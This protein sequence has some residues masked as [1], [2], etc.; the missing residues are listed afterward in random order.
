[1]SAPGSLSPR[2]R[3]E[4]VLAHQRPDRVPCDFGGCSVTGMH[5]SAVY[6]LR[7]A[8]RLDPPGTPVKVIDPFQMLGEI[9]PDLIAAL[10][11]DTVPLQG[12]GTFFGSPLDRWKPWTTF[13]GT[14]VLVP[15]D[16]NRD[17]NPDGSIYQYPQG[18]RTA[19]PSGEK[20]AGGFYF[21]TIQRGAPVDFDRLRVEDNTEEFSLIPDAE[22]AHLARE[23]ERLYRTTDQAIFASFPGGGFGDLAWLPAPFLKR[24]K[25]IRDYKDWLLSLLQRPGFV[26]EIFERQCSVALQN[27]ARLYDAVGNRVSLIFLT[28]ADYGTQDRLFF[29]P[30]VWTELYASFFRR[31]TD[32]IHRHTRWKVFCHSCGAIEPLIPHFIA[33]GFDILNPVQCSAAGMD[34]A[35][36]KRQSGD[37]VVFWGGGVDTQRTLPFGTPHEVRAEV[38]ERITILGCGGGYVFNS[39]HNLQPGTPVANLL[40]MFEAC[41]SCRDEGTAAE[42]KD[43][44]PIRKLCLTP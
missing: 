6:A 2:E 39:V 9:Q 7:Q 15:G 1:M 22:L 25:G 26:R 30:R 27:L 23:A 14:P 10:G 37:A 40:A 24:P 3:V 28:G 33:A 13:E 12:T 42:I 41:W 31:L 5:V 21:D 11:I 8:L 36:L 32:W 17:P 19:P 20:P 29:S 44:A 35:R 16:F 18:D 34:A 4:R 38:R 43:A